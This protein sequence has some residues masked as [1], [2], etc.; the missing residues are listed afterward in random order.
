MVRVKW[1][2]AAL[3]VCSA[4]D[5]ASQQS[6]NGGVAQVQQS[7]AKAPLDPL[8]LPPFS[9]SSSSNFKR[10]N[11]PRGVSLAV[12]NGWWMLDVRRRACGAASAGVRWSVV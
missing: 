3:L 6:A 4:C 10:V 12:P 11:L 5:S 1:A 2:A 8:D 9:S 7:P